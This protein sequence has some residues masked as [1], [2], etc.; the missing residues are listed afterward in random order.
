MGGVLSLGSMALC[1]TGTCVST[2]CAIC[3]SSCGNSGLAKFMYAL[4]LLV[5]VVISCI[6]LAPGI[7]TWLNKSPFCEPI[8][9][10]DQDPKHTEFIDQ[11]TDYGKK[12]IGAVPN[13]VIP[14]LPCADAIGYL[15]VY[16]ICFVVVIFFA[17]MAVL[18][19]GV[20]TSR[21]PRGPLQNG[22]W[23]IKFIL[24]FAGWIAA[25]FIPHGSFGPVMMW[26]GMIGGLAFILVQLVLIV[27]FAHTW[28]ET[29]QE[30]YRSSADQNWFWAL[31]SATVFFYIMC[32]V[33]I[34]LCFGYY[35]GLHTGDC[36]LHEFF[37]SFN[38]ILCLI[39]S[40]TSVLPVIQENQPNSGLLQAS[41]VSLYIIYLTWSAMSNQPD[42]LCKPDISSWFSGGSNT[43]STNI[44]VSANQDVSAVHIVTDQRPS[45]DTA[46][47]IGLIIWFACVLYSSIR[48]SSNAQAA[49]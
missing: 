40:V 11:L 23:G 12:V 31:L 9:A 37:I 39:L 44:S 1:L 14:K 29:W 30:N 18:M 43:Q 34:G 45:M 38:M 36:R 32:L 16:R 49:R 6:M 33:G 27:D 19:I 7:E 22:F 10:A 15:A 48:S 2:T 20:R 47:I 21:D 13:A 28:A 4:V 41:F 35:T 8:N 26:F 17:I 24:L 46:S 42:K 3:P 5:T 25:F